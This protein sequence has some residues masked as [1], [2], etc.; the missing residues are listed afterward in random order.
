M[1]LCCDAGSA[2]SGCNSAVDVLRTPALPWGSYGRMEYRPKREGT[3]LHFAVAL[4]G[5]FDGTRAASCS[6]RL[7]YMFFCQRSSGLICLSAGRPAPDNYSFRLL[8]PALTE[9]AS[10][11]VARRWAFAPNQQRN[12]VAYFLGCARSQPAADSPSSKGGTAC[13]PVWFHSVTVSMR[14]L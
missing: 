5:G 8:I 11:P 7:L 14:V 1:L 4:P 6:Q 2:Q 9:Q 13:K 12:H 10:P 3:V